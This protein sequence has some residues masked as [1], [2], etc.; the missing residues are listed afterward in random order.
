MR[1][2]R[3]A[4]K[5]AALA[6]I[7]AT[8]LAA[9]G[10]SSTTTG[11]TSIGT[12]GVFGKIPAET[13]TPHPGTVKVGE[14]PSS[15][16]SWILP[17]ITAADNSVYTV[18]SFDYEMF[19][20]L[21]FTVNGV[22]PTVNEPMSLAD[23]PVWSNN[24]KTATIT[25]KSNYKWSDG[26]PVSAQ[27][28]VFWYEE[29][30]AALKESPANWA[31][32][33]PDLGIPDQVTSVVAKSASTVVFNLKASVN[34]SWVTDDELSVIQPMPVQAWSKA[35]ATGPNIDAS[36]PANAK[37][38]YDYLAGASKPSASWA[39][40]PTWG[41][42]DGPYKLTAF[43]VTSGAYT[44]VPNKTYGGPKSK[45]YPTLQ[46]VP[47]TSDDAEVNALKSG[48]VDVGYLPVNDLGQLS[49]LSK[50]YVDYG[51]PDFGWTYAAYN[52][53]DT[54]GDF[55][56]IIGQLYIRQAIAHL[57]NEPGYIK[58][59]FNGAGGQAYGPVPSV[60]KSPY[61]PSNALTNPYPYS[62]SA[63][64]KL[65]SSHGWKVTPGGTDTCTSPGTAATDCG[66]GIPAG[67]KLA[68]PVVYGTSPAVIGE[69]LTDLASQ[70]SKVGIKM[71]LVSS[72]FNFIVENYNDPA[73]PK[74]DSKW[75][76]EDFGGFTDS[77]YPTTLGVFNS[78][79]SSN[80]GG[81]ADPE[82]DKLI[83]ASVNSSNP[84]AVKAEAS[85]LTQQQPGL[86]QPNPVSPNAAV[87]VYK[88]TLSGPPASF[89]NLTQFYLTPEFWYFTTKQ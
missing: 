8:A 79:G 82:A 47:F 21:Y 74:N 9:C 80:L 42:V 68:F 51:Y 54:T 19:R 24:D 66:A 27:D 86:F 29:L 22:E 89:A 62:T 63:A 3:P 14:P 6:A 16:P 83:N 4:M 45:D 44:M 10:K 1:F 57:E 64:A 18:T 75:A 5:V 77:T 11:G 56:K 40:N 41:T 30:K 38:I 43:N 15:A 17:L 12:A 61:T 88:K 78:A 60:P 37:K 84:A 36:V 46:T 70:A 31:Y 35:S 73:V 20:P 81:Y 71:T 7:G 76:M 58:A 34:P 87:V 48:A 26:S 49:S 69:Q 13:G 33:T 50:T 23:M 2:A 53:K 39:T 72:N 85:Y 28:V 52:F 67:T 32:Y 25:L 55:D 65:L 59:F